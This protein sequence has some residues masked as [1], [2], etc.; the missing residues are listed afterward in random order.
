MADDST[1]QAAQHPRMFEALDGDELGD[2]DAVVALDRRYFAAAER[3][4]RYPD[5]RRALS[6]KDRALIELA[7]DALVTQLDETRLEEDIRRA[8]ESGATRDEVVCVI[9]II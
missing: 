4:L 1:L 2:W 6:Q 9:E 7:F 3:L 8:A 5:E